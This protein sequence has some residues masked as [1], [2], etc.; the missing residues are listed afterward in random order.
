M[1]CIKCFEYT[2][3]KTVVTWGCPKYGGDSTAVQPQLNQV[4]FIIKKN[5][6]HLV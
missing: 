1:C 6:Q 2:M 5:E 4:Y 3:Y